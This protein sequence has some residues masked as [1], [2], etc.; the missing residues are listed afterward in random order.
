Q[1]L[2]NEAQKLY[3]SLY[4]F[5]KEVGACEFDLDMLEIIRPA[6]Q[7]L[8]EGLIN[9]LSVINDGTFEII[10]KTGFNNALN[11]NKNYAV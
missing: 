5:D 7:S 2:N 8:T 9:R 1:A 6:L 10:D 3:S 4:S 11:D